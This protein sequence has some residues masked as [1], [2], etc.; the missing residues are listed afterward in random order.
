M[1][2]VH[3]DYGHYWGVV[4]YDQKAKE[5]TIYLYDKKPFTHFLLIFPE[6]R[7][8]VLSYPGDHLMDVEAQAH[9]LIT[10]CEFMPHQQSRSYSISI[11]TMTLNWR[12]VG[13][14]EEN[15]ISKIPI[16]NMRKQL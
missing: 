14:K 9:E 7:E 6:T 12:S 13:K 2:E 3:T 11:L 16:W 15:E 10:E 1:F 4:E 5:Q 8:P